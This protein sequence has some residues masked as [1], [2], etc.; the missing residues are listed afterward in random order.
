MHVSALA[1]F[2]ET[3]KLGP[4]LNGQEWAFLG[5]HMKKIYQFKEIVVV[6]WLIIG[7]LFV[8]LTPF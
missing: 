3:K 7:I 1:T 4:G 2:P 6:P 5:S 8:I